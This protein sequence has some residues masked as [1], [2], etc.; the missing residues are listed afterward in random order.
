MS[1]THAVRPLPPP[2]EGGAGRDDDIRR[3][4]AVARSVVGFDVA[5]LSRFDACE[6][7]FTHVSARRPGPGPAE[8]SASDLDGS[9]CV[10]VLDGRLPSVVPDVD[11]EPAAR[12]L[13][14]TTALGIGAYAGVPVVDRD[15]RVHGM[16]CCTHG[17]AV[18]SVG[19]RERSALE[20]LAQVIGAL[21]EDGAGAR[22]EQQRMRVQ[23]VI[24]GTGRSHVLQ[25]IVDVRTGRA[26]G[27]EAL[28]RFSEEPYRPDLWFALADAV[29]LLLPL[30]LAAARTALTSLA[31]RTGHLSVNLSPETILAGECDVLLQDVDRSRVIVEITEHAQVADYEALHAALEPHRAAGLRLAVDDAG[32]GYASFRHILALRPDFIKVDLSLVRDIHL[33]PVRQALTSS[34]LTF[35]Q[36]AGAQLIA[37]GVETQAELDTLARLG[38]TLVQGYFL[39]RPTEAPAQDGYR[40]PS[41]HVLVDG[42][43]D[44]SL[45]LA[46]ALRSS[47]DLEGLTRPLLDAVLGLTGLETSYLTVL[48][49]SEHLEHR[50]VRNAGTIELPEGLTVPWSQALCSSMQAQGLTWTNDAGSDLADRPVAA[51][52]GVVTFLT[53]PVTDLDGTMLGTLCAGSREP[54]YISDATVA[55]VQ[56]IAH[57]LGREL[58]SPRTRERPP[59]R[60][61]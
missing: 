33:D 23:D 29:G 18:P 61:G 53:S 30:D 17:T 5:W 58:S 36:T 49:D 52:Q 46:N 11:E 27:A 57:V 28:S 24:D 39:G 48:H 38:V 59:A 7:T 6:Q 8:G 47:A 54:V 51:A 60:Q 1:S 12:E 13:P 56:L 16:L 32:A 26:I 35:A 10:R 31:H 45:V 37:E 2:A 40:V 41:P 14:V 21:L 4:L 20:M 15:G 25:P 42:G 50:F 44:L 9:Y 19:P 34:L 3:I 55:Q 43:G 22:D